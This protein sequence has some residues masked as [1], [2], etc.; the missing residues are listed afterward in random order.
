MSQPEDPK[1]L[2]H[3]EE[4]P[5]KKMETIEELKEEFEEPVV[6]R[7]RSP[8]F[9]RDVPHTQRDW[10]EWY[11]HQDK[12]AGKNVEDYKPRI[13]YLHAK[14]KRKI[15]NWLENNAPNASHLKSISGYWKGYVEN[16]NTIYLEDYSDFTVPEEEL[17]DFL[18]EK[19][20]HQLFKIDYRTV[21]SCPKTV[22]EKIRNKFKWKII[23]SKN[24][25]SDIQYENSKENWQTYFK[26]VI[27]LN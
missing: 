9:I 17:K 6:D 20:L 3:V 22:S 27:D 5:E 18:S 12:L 14:S 11:E 4:K 1:K 24:P 21:S 13:T 16:K 19:P 2:E 10:E 8:A 26:E 23:C 25:P 15:E 7:S